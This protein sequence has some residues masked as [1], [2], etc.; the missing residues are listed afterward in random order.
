MEAPNP[1]PLSR[2]YMKFSSEACA[3]CH[4][5]KCPGQ[6]LC[7]TL[8]V[9]PVETDAFLVDEPRL[10]V[11]ETFFFFMHDTAS[12]W[13]VSYPKRIVFL[14]IFFSRG[15]LVCDLA[16]QQCVFRHGHVSSETDPLLADKPCLNMCSR[17]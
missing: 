4:A 14:A 7:P 9:I 17:R 1:P 2:H 3:R 15:L 5:G 16:G 12:R 10:K 13:A 11:N 8:G 6:G